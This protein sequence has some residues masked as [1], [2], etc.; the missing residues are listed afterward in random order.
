MNIVHFTQSKMFHK[1][2]RCSNC[3]NA[4]S[5]KRLAEGN[6]LCMSC[7]EPK[8]NTEAHH[9]HKINTEGAQCISCHMPVKTY[10]G[11]DHRR[12]HSFR[13]PRPD[14][15]I[16]WD[17]P[18][19]CTGCHQE[20]SN[21]W[22]AEAVKKWYGPT[23]AYHF[24][25]DLLP[26]SELTDKSESHLLKLLSDITQPEIARGTAAYY[27]GSIQT[28]GSVNGLLNALDDKKP[29]VRYHA[30]RALE[31]FQPDWWI[32][33]AIA[34]LSDN[35]R[36]VRIAAADLFHR[37]PAESIPTSARNAYQAANAENKKYLQYQTDFAV[38]NVMLADYELQ[39][40]DH[41]NAIAHYIRGLEKDSLMNYARLNLS[42]AY[43]IAGKNEEA[44]KTL[45]DAATID[46]KNPRV[47]YNLALLQYEIGNTD[48]AMENFQRA[49]KVGSNDAGVYYN[50]GLLLQ[51]QG[52][53]KEAEQILL[54]GVS[55]NPQA[56]NIHYA[57]S[58]LY[59]NQG[60]TQKARTYAEKL[61]RIDPNNPEYQGLYR[62]VG[63]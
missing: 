16:V 30:I 3:H 42:A 31:N 46:P 51:Q 39:E 63:L 50:Y 48:A 44:L 21:K 24:S 54:K 56:A 43:N 6:A 2:V 47:F 22:A 45:N 58:Y 10:M 49:I 4:H 28:P 53:I 5:G 19:A 57:L 32:Q 8:Y 18:N 25:D 38:G 41:L 11:N 59:I 34:A 33:K 1:E 60:Q 37:L 15:S 14:Q 55:T 62:S 12:D 40:N 9:F 52:K 29:L 61:R 27:L 35:V 17:T 23:R 20:K 36:A 13:I 26:G 7:H